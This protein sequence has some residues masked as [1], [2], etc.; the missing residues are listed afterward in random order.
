M[1]LVL[2][3]RG[4][5]VFDGPAQRGRG[6]GAG[7]HQLALA[8]AGGVQ[9]GGQ[10]GAI[11]IEGAPG[12]RAGFE[13]VAGGVGNDVI[14]GGQQNDIIDVG[15]ESTRPYGG[16]VAV[17][18]DGTWLAAGEVSYGGLSLWNLR[19]R[20]EVR[21]P[22]GR[23]GVRVAFSPREPLLAVAIGADVGCGHQRTTTGAA[24]TTGSHG[25][26][27]SVAMSGFSTKSP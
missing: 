9:F 18:A 27:R 26:R 1:S 4:A 16:A 23:S 21:L 6:V 12:E 3:Q 10:I 14:Y 25:V 5:D 15:A 11:L 13:N 22:A 19:T 17:S 24:S 20:E 2:S 7:G 8:G